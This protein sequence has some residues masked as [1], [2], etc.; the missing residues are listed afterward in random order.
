M[1]TETMPG[2]RALG[3]LGEEMRVCSIDGCDNPHHSR[4]WCQKHYMRWYTNADAAN[5]A[6]PPPRRAAIVRIPLADVHPDKRAAAWASQ[7][8]FDVASRRR[9]R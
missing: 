9:E 3:D 6:I 5:R 7:V 8:R 4:G 2:L 1:D